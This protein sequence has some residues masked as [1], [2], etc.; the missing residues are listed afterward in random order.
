M[1]R[2]MSVQQA[3][4]IALKEAEQH[5]IDLSYALVFP[6]DVQENV[7]NQTG[8]FVP[9]DI[10]TSIS[11]FQAFRESVHYHQELESQRK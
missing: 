7:Q 10:P 6:F 5:I 2:K 3:R 1:T 4:R 11:V 9:V 8:Q